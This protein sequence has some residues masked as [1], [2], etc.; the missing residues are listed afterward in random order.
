MA[1]ERQK[2]AVSNLVENR[3]NVSQAMKDAGYTDA[4]AK[5]PSNLTKSAGFAELME[6]YLPDDMLLGALADDIEKKEGNRK[7]EMELAFKLK[8]KMIE[9]KDITSNGQPINIVMPE[10]VV[11]R[12]DEYTTPPETEGSN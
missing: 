11:E 10:E 7:A 8:G 9:K 6:A 12:T 2:Q 5:N 3:G 4:S 1:T